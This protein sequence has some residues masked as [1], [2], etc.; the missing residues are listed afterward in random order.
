MSKKFSLTFRQSFFVKYSSSL[1]SLQNFGRPKAS[2]FSFKAVQGRLYTLFW[3]KAYTQPR[4]ESSQNARREMFCLQN[5]ARITHAFLNVFVH[6][7]LSKQ[8]ICLM[9]LL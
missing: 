3:L 6:P 9:F 8:K 4:L 2:N 1:L 5:I 7:E